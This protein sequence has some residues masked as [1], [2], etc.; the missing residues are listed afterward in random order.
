MGQK[1]AECVISNYTVFFCN[2]EVIWTHSTQM[3]E[4]VEVY[5]IVFVFKMRKQKQSKI[6]VS[7]Q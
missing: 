2:R 3:K 1:A 5:L 4:A 7:A 6:K